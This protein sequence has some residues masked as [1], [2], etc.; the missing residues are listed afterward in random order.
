MILKNIYRFVV[1]LLIQVLLINNITLG[2]YVYPAFYIYFILLLPFE[3]KGW[4]LLITAFLMGLGV[5]FFFE[6]TRS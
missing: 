3:T 1:V 2:T 6:L 5:D 4:V